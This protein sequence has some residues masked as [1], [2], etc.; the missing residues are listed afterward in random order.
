MGEIILLYEPGPLPALEPIMH[1]GFL[2]HVLCRVPLVPCYMDGNEHPTI[3]RRFYRSSRVQHGRADRHESSGDGSRLYE[4]NMWMW[5]FG[6]L[7][8]SETQRSLWSRANTISLCFCITSQAA[9]IEKK[10]KKN[11]RPGINI[12]FWEK[13]GSELL[14]HTDSYWFIYIYNSWYCFILVLVQKNIS[15]HIG[16]QEFT[17]NHLHSCWI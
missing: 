9:W 14:I 3:P 8:A 17:S 2:S 1:V 11:Q 5:K 13:Y 12:V 15:F 7:R 4:V 6:T 16:S 10:E